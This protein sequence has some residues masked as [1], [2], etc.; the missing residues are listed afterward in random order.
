MIFLRRDCV[1]DNDPLSRRFRLYS[2][3]SPSCR[4]RLLSCRNIGG[5]SRPAIAPH[6]WTTIHHP[7]ERTVGIYHRA[8]AWGKSNALIL[9]I[10]PACEGC[11]SKRLFAVFALVNLY[12]VRRKLLSSAV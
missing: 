11:S 12:L 10:I 4:T 8:F 6:L 7:V 1:Y 2:A 3:R 5:G 9:S